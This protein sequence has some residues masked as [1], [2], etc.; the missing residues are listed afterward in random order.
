MD[1]LAERFPALNGG[2]LCLDFANTL[3]PLAAN[4]EDR[5]HLGSDRRRADYAGMLVWFTYAGVLDAPARQRLT[6]LAATRPARARHAVRTALRL[7]AAST[8]VFA[9]V[10]AGRELPAEHVSD[11]RTLYARAI[12]AA[13]LRENDEQ[14]TW[15]WNVAADLAGPLRPVVASVI[16]LLTSPRL[17]RVKQCAGERCW[18]LFADTTKNKSRRWCQMRYCGNVLKSQRQAGRRRRAR[19]AQ[20]TFS[21]GVT[22]DHR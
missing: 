10:A 15:D 22:G 13:D 16:D 20:R 9:A 3:E 5:D 17:A 1:E 21:E 2:A 11:L 18:V 6:D 8:A 4:G 12:L 14:P 7:R 19:R